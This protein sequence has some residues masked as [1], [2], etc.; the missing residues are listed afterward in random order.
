MCYACGT[1][2]KDALA[3][4]ELKAEAAEGQGDDKTFIKKPQIFVK[5]IVKK[6]T[7]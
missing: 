6:K 1:N 7:V 5:K 3:K 4:Q 2:V